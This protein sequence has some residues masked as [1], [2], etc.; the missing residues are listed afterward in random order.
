MSQ[1]PVSFEDARDAIGVLPSLEP[2]PTATN[3]QALVIDLVDKLTIIPSQ[4]SADLGYSGLVQQD[5]LYAL[6]TN[7][8][9][10]NWPDPGAHR[11]TNA[12]WSTQ[13]QKDA[14]VVYLANKR[15]YDSEC[16]VL[17]AIIN[18]LNAAVPRKYKRAIGNAIGVKIYRPTDSPKT[19]LNNL[20]TNYGKL[21]PA[22]KTE[23]ERKWSAP[24][25]PS[26]PIEELFDR[27]ETC[28]VL[29][30]S[31]KLAYTQEQMID[32][33]L[34]AVQTTGLFSIAVLEWN[35]FDKVNQI[36][37]EFKSHFTEAH[38]VH[39]QSG[40]ET[41]NVYHG[42]A[43]AYDTADDDVSVGSITQSLTSMHLANNANAQSIHDTMSTIT[44][45]TAA[46]RAAL[47]ATQ[48]QLALYSQQQP[49]WAATQYP[50]QAPPPPP[51]YMPA[52]YATPPPPAHIPPPTYQ[53]PAD[54]QYGGG[55]RGGGRGGGGGG[56]GG[57]KNGR[58]RRGAGFGAQP[59]AAGG[60]PRAAGTATNLNVQ[61]PV[62]WYNNWN[63]CFSCGFDIPIWHTSKTCP[64]EC[65][66]TG[67]QELC[68]RQ[69][70]QQYKAAGHNVR[71]A[72]IGKTQLPTNARPD[73]A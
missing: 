36:W 53:R 29:A 19:I 12:A 61:N 16:N 1:P 42:A 54:Q 45:D 26:N 35:G 46:L 22:E 73:Q 24:W 70:Y 58:G 27:L 33:A 43:N 52:A 6:A 5:E 64:A 14:E 8:P 60:V 56:R 40:G 55:G 2:R 25:N 20:R 48:Q 57:K 9:W 32:K 37:S 10:Q 50:P 66:S 51:T 34:M 28:Y 47:A 21:G 68:D 69:N 31:A 7:Q 49:A 41:T 67:H 30:L 38:D 17:R 63:M 15:V 18:G 59:P 65:R 71:M 62:K 13:Q 72:K 4:Q 39:L 3:I 23:N 11:E 44:A